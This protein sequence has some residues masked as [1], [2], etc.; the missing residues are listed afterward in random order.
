MQSF[1]G[2]QEELADRTIQVRPPLLPQERNPSAVVLTQM[3]RVNGAQA[4]Q[5]H[6]QQS[7]GEERKEDEDRCGICLE[8]T[9]LQESLSPRSIRS[10]QL[11][12]CVACGA[13]FHVK[14]LAHSY[15]SP[16]Q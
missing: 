8:G 4:R 12:N 5:I 13:F 14:V 10:R 11:V 15:S 2:R 7:G 16:L 9:I 3:L 1:R 6:M